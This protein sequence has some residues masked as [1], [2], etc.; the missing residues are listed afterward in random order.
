MPRK[1]TPRG[2]F[3]IT[4]KDGALHRH[5]MVFHKNGMKD[6][7]DY[8]WDDNEDLYVYTSKGYSWNIKNISLRS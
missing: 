5:D 4:L 8:L 3:L 6:Y 7:V 1:Q 2:D